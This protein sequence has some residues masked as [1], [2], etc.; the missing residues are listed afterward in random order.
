[1]NGCMTDGELAMQWSARFK[2]Y[3]KGLDVSEDV[4]DIISVLTLNELVLEQAIIEV[5]GGSL[6][7]I[8]KYRA[9]K[10]EKVILFALE[11]I[12]LDDKIN[13]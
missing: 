10:Y 5:Y 12:K 9:E 8:E 7:E 6:D 13:N 3:L 11:L 2:G 4:G 1:M